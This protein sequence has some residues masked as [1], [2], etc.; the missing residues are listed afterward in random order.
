MR[1]WV[2]RNYA[3]A[4]LLS[5]VTILPTALGAKQA[6]AAVQDPAAARIN[7]NIPAQDLGSA[8]SEF[9]RQS[10][11]QLLYSPALVRGKTSAAVAG[12][13]TAK[14]GL[15]HL[16]AGTGVRVTTA[17]SGAFLLKPGAPEGNG[18]AAA[19]GDDAVQATASGGSTIV[20]TGSRLAKVAPTS[21]VIVLDEKYIQKSGAGNVEDVVRNIPQNFSSLTAAS[22]TQSPDALGTISMGVGAI[23]LRGIG[24]DSTLVLI[25]GR[26]TAGSGAL[27]GEAVNI[28]TIPLSAIEKIEILTDGASAIYG[29]DAIAGVVNIILKRN[30]GFSADSHAR[31]ENSS[32]GG[33]GYSLDQSLSFGWKTG[34]INA[35][36]SYRKVK[37][38]DADEI[39]R[40]FDYR[41]RGGFDERGLN[42]GQ[43][44]LID[45]AFFDFYTL[46]R[47][48]N[49]VNYTPGDLIRPFLVDPLTGNPVVDALGNPVLSPDF[50]APT[51]T[52]FVQVTP[53]T[54]TL[55]ARIGIEQEV[56]RRVKVFADVLYSKN[57]VRTQFGVPRIF[58]VFVPASNAFNNLGQDVFV[59]YSPIYEVAH[60][61][62]P[63]DSALN[64]QKRIDMDGG[65]QFKDFIGD[66][67]S[68]VS[69]TLSRD[70]N[71]FSRTT[72]D[73]NSAEFDAALASS[74]P[75]TA[76]NLFGNGTG[77]N[78]AVLASLVSTDVL[79]ELRV[80]LLDFEGS[81][82][83]S[84]FHLPGGDVR[85]AFGGEHRNEKLH[86]FTTS[87]SISTRDI[88]AAFGELAVPIFGDQFSFPGMQS[89]L[90]TAAA[91]WEKYSVKGDFN[92]DGDPSND[93]DRTFKKVSPKLGLRWKPFG[94]LTLLGTWGRSFRAPT[95]TSLFGTNIDFPGG[96]F[97]FLD[98]LAPG[99]PAVVKPPLVF[100]PNL[101][102][103]PE[104]STSWTAAAT[105]QPAFVPRLRFTL[106]YNKINFRDR[107]TSGFDVLRGN[108]EA[109]L[110]GGGVPG[111]VVERNA[112]G[113]ITKIFIP[114][115]VNAA[116]RRS[117]SV[118][119][120]AS[121]DLKTSRAGEFNFALS[122]T[123]TL[124]LKE[125]AFVGSRVIQ[126]A[127]T[128]LGPSKWVETGQLGWTYGALDSNV[129]VHHSS[130]YTNTFPNLGFGT[131]DP[132]HVDSYTTVDAN[133]TYTF[134]SPSRVLNKVRVAV[135]AR[136]L[137]NAKFPFIDYD[138]GPFDPTRVDPRGRV[139]YLDITKSF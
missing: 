3:R 45:V 126:L 72:I 81:A 109:V 30:S 136:N 82:N 128:T 28:N 46:P 13:Y 119:F 86:G 100:T 64:R 25:N 113:V 14:E 79:D 90:F 80:R 115:Q 5:S 129:F 26:R 43:P 98:P 2:V 38:V 4:L 134:A 96:I 85:L 15:E 75:A 122:G 84:L 91:R 118:D 21:P 71:K 7:L 51:G 137:F 89:L 77:Q 111:F 1:S 52:E 44:G 31:Y 10:N 9:A 103:R 123:R 27:N 50:A 55:S 61:V 139:I 17:T 53:E 63:P 42:G 132:E 135:G 92:N 117:K 62:I 54:K 49:G 57:R 41:D 78:N 106:G 65:A 138:T 36:L 97:G 34:N 47:G 107:L 74:D 48:N 99:G 59:R 101:E 35:G 20:V 68:S 6:V 76:I 83:G 105:Y 120:G 94:D 8:L 95:A 133:V 18:S 40:T 124:K 12:Q 32:N 125:Q 67:T 16:L 73:T 60:G 88:D 121:Y 104:N 19:T 33:D 69:A 56:G 39:F 58:D 112:A 70:S 23:N 108:P 29:S 22:A 93:D 11:Q 116:A 127:G 37:A 24:A 66:W 131:R 110:G 102:L 87:L 114:R 130:G